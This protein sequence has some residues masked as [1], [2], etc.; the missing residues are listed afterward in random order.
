MHE[1]LV[2]RIRKCLREA[3]QEGSNGFIYDNDKS[4]EEQDED[5]K[6]FED[7]CIGEIEDLE[8]KLRLDGEE[9]KV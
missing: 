1:R 8:F 5:W 2:N 9:Y 6:Y 4:P 7:M 3:S